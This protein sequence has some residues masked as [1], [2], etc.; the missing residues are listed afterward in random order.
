M[1]CQFT[2][3]PCK[4]HSPQEKQNFAS[5]VTNFEYSLL[6]E[7]SNINCNKT[8]ISKLNG[9]KSFAQ[10]PLLKLFSG[11]TVK[12]TKNQISNFPGPLQVCLALLFAKQIVINCTYS[13]IHF[14]L[15]KFTDLFTCNLKSIITVYYIIYGQLIY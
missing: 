14:A 9:E 12:T 11:N 8:Q 15:A 2:V 6:N 13:L 5:I 1:Y 4:F 7:L 3:F 10:F